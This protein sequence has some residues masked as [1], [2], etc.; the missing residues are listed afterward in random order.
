MKTF[1]FFYFFSV[2]LAKCEEKNNSTWPHLDVVFS[3][4]VCTETLLAVACVSSVPAEAPTT[5]R[6]IQGILLDF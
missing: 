3:R 1:N 5:F 2:A 4:E 6:P